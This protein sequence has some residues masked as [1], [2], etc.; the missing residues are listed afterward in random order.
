MEKTHDNGEEIAEM[1][2]D[3]PSLKLAVA[4][5]MAASYALLTFV[6][7]SFGYSWIQVR[8]SEALAPLPFLMG[9]PAVAGLTVGCVLANWFSPIGL[10]DMIFGPALTLFAALLSWKF[11]FKRKV[12]A[13]VYPIVVNAFGVSAYVSLFYNVPYPMSV[14]TIALGESIAAMLIGYPLLVALERT[15]IRA[16]GK[17]VTLR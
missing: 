5:L 2:L 1:D 15:G 12:V 10:P 17:C 7:G 13:C 8:I 16:R 11:N 14:A 6:L 4:S 3:K 9:F